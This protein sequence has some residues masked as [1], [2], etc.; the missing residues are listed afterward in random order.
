MLVFDVWPTMEHIRGYIQPYSRPVNPPTPGSAEPEFM[1]PIY[2]SLVCTGLKMQTEQAY[3][4]LNY[5]PF[6]QTMVKH[7]PIPLFPHAPCKVHKNEALERPGKG[8]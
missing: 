3:I 8:I 2:P 4:Q 1:P 7:T 5:V 6:S